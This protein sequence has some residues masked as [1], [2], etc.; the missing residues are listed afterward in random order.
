MRKK[1]QSHLVRLDYG[2]SKPHAVIAKTIKGRGVSFME[3][4]PEWH[5][6]IPTQEEC[7]K[8]VAGLEAA[9]RGI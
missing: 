4:V 1:S 3:N 9:G 6:R 2:G 5:H 8:A 7:D